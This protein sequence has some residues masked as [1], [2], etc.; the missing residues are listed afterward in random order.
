MVTGIHKA[1]NGASPF[2]WS[3]APSPEF[4]WDCESQ[5]PRCGILISKSFHTSQTGG[6]GTDSISPVK[7]HSK[8]TSKATL[9]MLI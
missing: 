9:E 8:P 3:P 5:Q 2:P 1:I 7:L 6:K 4:L